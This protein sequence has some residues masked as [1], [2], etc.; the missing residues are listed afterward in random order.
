MYVLPKPVS[1][2]YA[3]P[4]K[5]SQFVRKLFNVEMD[6]NFTCSLVGINFTLH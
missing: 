5:F 2:Y 1:H 6:V 4:V 3:I